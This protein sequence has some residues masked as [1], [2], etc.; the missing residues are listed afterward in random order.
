MISDYIIKGIQPTLDELPR[1][2]IYAAAII[3]LNKVVTN[4]RVTRLSNSALRQSLY[5][6]RTVL[7]I[8]AYAMIGFAVTPLTDRYLIG[9]FPA[10]FQILGYAFAYYL[11][12]V[13]L[14]PL[15][16]VASRF[17]SWAFDRLDITISVALAREITFDGKTEHCLVCGETLTIGQEVIRTFGL[18]PGRPR[19]QYWHLKCPN[20]KVSSDSEWS[21]VPS[22]LRVDMVFM[23]TFA[24]LLYAASI[25]ASGIYLTVILRDFSRPYA[26]IGLIATGFFSVWYMFPKVRII[27]GRWRAEVHEGQDESWKQGIEKY[28]RWTINSNPEGLKLLPLKVYQWRQKTKR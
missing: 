4:Q 27:W 16:Y 9:T 20:V 5:F 12:L 18:S 1:V 11:S 13:L 26:N 2:V 24:F 23:L 8:V 22:F 14:Y 21:K 19:K 17:V 15:F 6:L 3:L 25:F 28:G 10:P 7:P